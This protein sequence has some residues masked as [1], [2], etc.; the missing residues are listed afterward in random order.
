VHRYLL[1]FF[2]SL[3]IINS[4]SCENLNARYVLYK[5]TIITNEK[6]CFENSRPNSE[7]CNPILNPKCP[8]SI[9]RKDIKFK[10][11]NGNI[12]NPSFRL[13]HR[14]QGSPQI[15]DV[16]IGKNNWSTFSRCFSQDLKEFVDLDNLVRYYK[17]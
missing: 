11:L 14:L 8:F 16:E 10:D 7:N 3:N 15:Y 13:C 6:F 2:L 4:F 17:S 1:T 5:K 9:I 12:G